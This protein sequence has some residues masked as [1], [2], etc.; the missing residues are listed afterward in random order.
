[1]TIRALSADA[2]Q[3]LRHIHELGT[4]PAADLT[5]TVPFA[6]LVALEAAGLVET[7]AVGSDAM[8]SITADG[9]AAMGVE[10]CR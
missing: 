4:S 5:R 3:I 9:R 6:V 8:V 2:L 10:R 1:M 7:D